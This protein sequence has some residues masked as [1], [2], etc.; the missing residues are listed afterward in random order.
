MFVLVMSGLYRRLQR[1]VWFSVEYMLG[2]VS[3]SEFPFLPSQPH[4]HIFPQSGPL[5]AHSL[6][7]STGSLPDRHTAKHK[8]QQY[9]LN[10]H[11]SELSTSIRS[12]Q[13]LSFVHST[14]S[15][16]SPSIC[17]IPPPFLHK[18]FIPLPL[19]MRNF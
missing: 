12:C 15:F 8:P 7:L 9:D 19:S 5:L 10:P 4:T 13:V 14:R 2:T 1:G 6:P 16:S 17:L 18:G 3:T 11:G